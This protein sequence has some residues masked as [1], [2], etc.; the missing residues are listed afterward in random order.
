MDFTKSYKYIDHTADL[1]IEVRGKTIEELFTNTAKA[2]FDTQIKGKVRAQEELNFKIESSSLEELFVEWCRELLYNFSVKGFIPKKYDVS[3]GDN[4][5]IACLK[6]ERFDPKR[7]KIKLE[8]KN[9]TYHNLTI[10]KIAR[11][12][13]A[14][15]IFD[16]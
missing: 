13:I 5:L 4:T 11:D 15:I 10:K 3:I 1:G 2:V 7:H 16:V 9:P 12:Y 6:G 14:T 8:V